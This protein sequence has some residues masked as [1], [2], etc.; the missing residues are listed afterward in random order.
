MSQHLVE[1]GTL[2][3]PAKER[4]PKEKTTKMA[5]MVK[6]SPELAAVAGTDRCPR[7]KVTRL[8]WAYIK[9]NK[10]QDPEDGRRVLCDAKMKAVMGVDSLS[11]FEMTV[12]HGRRVRRRNGSSSI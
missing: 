2:L 12:R 6:L 10:L 1:C 3:E 8:L 11:M 9:A 4:K 7:S 5:I